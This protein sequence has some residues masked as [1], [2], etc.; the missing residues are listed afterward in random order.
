MRQNILSVAQSVD[1]RKHWLQVQSLGKTRDKKWQHFDKH[2]V[3]APPFLISALHQILC[4]CFHSLPNKDKQKHHFHNP[5]FCLLPSV[6]Q[7]LAE[8]TLKLPIQI[9]FNRNIDITG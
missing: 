3:L 7:Q 6:Y 8:T 4:Q 1:E 5:T 2:F 9:L